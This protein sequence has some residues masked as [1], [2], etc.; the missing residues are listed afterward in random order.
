LS[1]GFHI[2]E[3]ITTLNKACYIIRSVK[4]FISLEVLRT[5][6]FFLVHSII[7]YGLTFL[8]T[9]AYRKVIFKIHVVNYSKKLCILPLHS[10]YIFSIL[11][12]VVK[13]RGLYKTNFDVH[14]F[15]TRFNY[16]LHL[17]TAK[18]TIFK[19]GV[20]YLGIKIIN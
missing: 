4:P 16:D 3:I 10:Q 6:Y 9:S 5:I 11:L 13:N 19:K 20:C 14:K 7:M 1:W 15:N 2:D 17:P 12:F 8:G 18:F